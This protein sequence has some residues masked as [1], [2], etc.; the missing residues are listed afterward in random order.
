VASV[1][2]LV[3]VIGV[4]IFFLLLLGTCLQNNLFVQVSNN[5][6]I[7]H[8]NARYQSFINKNLKII[9]PFIAQRYGNKVDSYKN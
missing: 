6:Y 4:F 7:M 9:T 1:G 5:H 8:L 2:S 3:S